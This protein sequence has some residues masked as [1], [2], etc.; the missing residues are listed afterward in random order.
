MATDTATF[1]E[2]FRWGAATASYQIEGAAHEGGRGE[3]VWDR[4]AATPGKVRN[5]DT[6]EIACDFYHRYRED[7]ALM[8]ELG[9]DAFRFSIAWPRV[10]PEGRGRVNAAGPRLLRPPR[11]R[12]AR[13]RHRAVRDALPLGHAAGARGHG[14][15]ARAR[16]RRGIRRVHRSRRRAPRRPGAALDDAQ[17]AL[18][19]TPGS[20]TRWASTRPAG[21]ASATPSRRRTTCCCRTA[22]PCRRS[23]R[24]SPDAKVGI[25]LN[26]AHAVPGVGLAGGRGR[27]MGDR[28]RR[29]PLVPR[30]DLPRLVPGGSARAPR[31]R[32][33]VHPRRRPRGRRGADRLPRRQ[34][35]LPLRRRRRR[36]GAAARIAGA[37][38]RCTPTWAG[39]CTRTACTRC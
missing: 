14:R 6:G 21:R 32:G 8:S 12:A 33:A 25:V 5:G 30:P 27:G 9:L 28:R 39:R 35:L 13:A 37:P 26:L 31:D 38:R 19:R 36:R 11:R 2:D 24:A 22:G 10:L 3:S 20:V 1:P 34:Q 17:R 29:Q 18:G 7:I 4:F 15:L 16:D 23:A